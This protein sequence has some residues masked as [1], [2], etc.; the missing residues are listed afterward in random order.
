MPDPNHVRIV[1]DALNAPNGE[2]TVQMTF[3]ELILFHT[4]MQD[5]GIEFVGNDR[6]IPL[7]ERSAQRIRAI[8]GK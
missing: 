3:G 7:M 2:H 8:G 5:Y 6:F 4:L 1:N